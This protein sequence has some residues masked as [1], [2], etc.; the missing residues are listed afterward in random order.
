MEEVVERLV[1]IEAKLD[2]LLGAKATVSGKET[3]TAQDL[4]RFSPKQHAV[5]QMIWANVQTNDMAELLD[6]SESTIKVHVRGI[7]RK[8]GFKS[9][10]QIAMMA[11]DLLR[12][13]AAVYLRQ[14]GIP[15][16]WFLNQDTHTKYTAMLREKAR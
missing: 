4:L 5:I 11:D 7:M 2:V 14:A 16:D 6:V 13:D 12:T 10:A 3:S 15:Q 1:R 9:R 8:T